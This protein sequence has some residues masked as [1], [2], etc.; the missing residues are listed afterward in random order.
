MCLAVRLTL[1]V[2]FLDG[3]GAMAQTALPFRVVDSDYS[4]ALSRIVMISEAPNQLHIYDPATGVD[5]T[6]SLPKP[7][8]G[9]SLS[10][11]GLYAAVACGATVAYVNLTAAVVEKTF[12]TPGVVVDLVTANEYVHVDMGNDAVRSIHISSGTISGSP[13]YY[14][15]RL[16]NARLH[17][18]G[19]A[20]YTTR[21]NTS[22]ND[23]EKID[24]SAGPMSGS[25]D[26]PYHGDYPVCGPIWYSPDGSRIFNG[27]AT[28][29]TSSPNA[30]LEMTYKSALAG[31]VR[32]ASLSESAT[33]KRLAA[34]AA[35]ASS[36]YFPPDGA[37]KDNEILLF[38]GPSLEPQGRL[39]L[40]DFMVNATKYAAHGRWIFL[41]NTGT[42]LFAVIQADGAAG[43]LNDFAVQT[44]DFGNSAPC[45]PV[46]TPTAAAPPWEGATAVMEISAPANC[47]YVTSSDAPWLQIINHTVGSGTG[48]IRYH[49]RA[50]LTGSSRTANITIG[51]QI[52]PV[53]QGSSPAVLPA[54][55]Q[56][57]YPVID[58]EYSTTLDKSILVSDGTNELHIYNPV[59]GSDVSVAL[60]KAPLSVSV[61]PDGLFA[62]VGHDG[63]ISL[64]N[65]QTAQVEKVLDVIT[66][67]ADVLLGGERLCVCVSK[68]GLVR[69]V[70]SRDGDGELDSDDSHLYG[71][72]STASSRWAILLRGGE[73]DIEMDDSQWSHGTYGTAYPIWLV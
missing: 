65:L 18:S 68:T 67:V 10:P 24:V 50:N 71:A 28:V 25:S 61:R 57:S 43:L 63:W 58:G 7:P 30:R 3:F 41:D 32:V 4:A 44:F 55:V 33:S 38:D 8:V 62:A 42:R 54:T 40:A 70:F 66:D 60:F 9:L 52:V 6:V 51:G 53:T 29:F 37:P 11:N 48:T 19:S 64:V 47:M 23:I 22:P 49:A 26:S 39:R 5:R 14:Y 27:C 56:L 2:L 69:R 59:N 72:Q 31:M 21:D 12:D 35:G 15:R 45:V 17:P 16:I 1:C 34:L 73:L 13:N 46:V 20:I 36:G